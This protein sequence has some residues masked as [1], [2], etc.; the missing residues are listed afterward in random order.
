[1]ER[2]RSLSPFSLSIPSSSNRTSNRKPSPHVRVLSPRPSTEPPLLFD[3]SARPL[4]TQRFDIDL[5]EEKFITLK[6]KIAVSKHNLND[7]KKCF[8]YLGIIEE[9]EEITNSLSRNRVKLLNSFFELYISLQEEMKKNKDLIAKHQKLVQE[10]DGNLEGLTER[11]VT[12]KMKSL[13]NEIK[14]KMQIITDLTS[15][16]NY[17]EKY[18]ELKAN[19]DYSQGVS[20]ELLEKEKTIYSMQNIIKENLPESFSISIHEPCKAC[21]KKQTELDVLLGEIAKQ[22]EI[23]NNL[24][25][26]RNLFLKDCKNPAV[27]SMLE[28]KGL[29]V[30]WWENKQDSTSQ[31]WRRNGEELIQDLV[32][33]IEKLA[34]S[35][36]EQTG[37]ELR[38]AVHKKI[39][40]VEADFMDLGFQDEKVKKIMEKFLELPYLLKPLFDLLKEY[41]KKELVA[42]P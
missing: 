41:E 13:K 16:V 28:L 32:F 29:F 35:K 9:L 37:R 19:I 18:N 33:S 30:D 31:L 21:T 23:I 42:N 7:C 11:K 22:R 10:V 3:F 24:S 38:S 15:K 40:E 14:H 17:F 5:T 8:E 4:T 39:C 6:D 20:K 34:E 36:I 12:N 2:N 26:N 1:M 25:K 27:K